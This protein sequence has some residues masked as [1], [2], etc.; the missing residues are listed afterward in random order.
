[1][2]ALLSKNA[3]VRVVDDL[4]R[5]KLKNLEHCLDRI[6]FVKGDLSNS[7]TAEKAACGCSVCYHLAA[8][9]GDVRWMNT[10]PSEIFRSVLINYNIIDACRKREIDK[11]VYTSSACAYPVG[12]QSN[13]DF[14]PLKED[15]VLKCGAMPDGDYG[16]A[17]LMGEIQC[18]AYHETYGLKTAIVRPFNPY[19]P[20]ESF[21]V[22]DSHVIPA[23]IRRAVNHENPFI[24]WGD[25]EQRRAF[26][27]VTDLVDGIILAGENL[28]D[29]SPINLGE[30]K[31]TSI[32]EL[33]ELILKLTGYNMQIVWD[34]SKPE[35]VRVRKSDMTRASRV[36]KWAPRVTLEEGIR[37]TI[38]W[39]K[40]NKA[41]IV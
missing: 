8:V 38:D 15:D 22:E 14:P 5:G 27:Y 11:L 28:S 4:S 19:G 37:R 24:V 12:L 13:A 21:T 31:D 29:A 26:T 1:M 2:D 18:R 30:W 41:A 10:H 36:L 6:E 20:R 3:H 9:V 16:W 33:A 17:K 7:E 32:R 25:G 35:G 34:T 39:Y 23:L 40:E